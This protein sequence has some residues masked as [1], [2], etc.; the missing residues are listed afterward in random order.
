MLAGRRGKLHERVPCRMERDLI[1]SL[2]AS[3][4]R[5]QHRGVA[6]RGI[7]ERVCLRLAKRLA[8]RA[9]LRHRPL[10]I[11]ARNRPLQRDVGVEQ[12]EAFEWQ[13]L[14]G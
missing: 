1:D 6:I 12:V 5:A 9:Q 14:I 8:P 7:G 4:V 2:A 3:I 13:R 10:R 11:V